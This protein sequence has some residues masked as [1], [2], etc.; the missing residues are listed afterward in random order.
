[1]LV[2]LVLSGLV[3][4]RRKHHIIPRALVMLTWVGFLVAGALLLFLRRALI[5]RGSE[6]P[7]RAMRAYLF[8]L[9]PTGPTDS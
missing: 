4:Q 2:M 7:G 1:M 5:K 6:L 3:R 9:A 8:A